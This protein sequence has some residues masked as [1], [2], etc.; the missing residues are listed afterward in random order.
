MRRGGSRT[1]RDERHWLP[2]KERDEFTD[3]DVEI[4][5]RLPLS[6]A[7]HRTLEEIAWEASHDSVGRNQDAC[8]SQKQR[9]R[10]P[11]NKNSGRRRATS[12]DRNRVH[13]A[14]RPRQASQHVEVAGVRLSIPDR[15]LHPEHGITKLD[16]AHYYE[17][18][19]D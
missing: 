1:T 13:S 2:L 5:E 8:R 4:T 7:T 10:R 18:V 11:I 17:R 16:L 3:N 19:A 6:V 9:A 12:A 15:V 14:E